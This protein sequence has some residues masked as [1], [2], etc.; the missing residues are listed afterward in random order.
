VQRPRRR[1]GDRRTHVERKRCAS[2]VSITTAYTVCGARVS[3]FECVPPGVAGGRPRSRVNGTGGLCLTAYRFRMAETGAT[4]L[5]QQQQQHRLYSN[6]FV[7][8][9]VRVRV[10]CVPEY[11]RDSPDKNLRPSL[12]AIKFLFIVIVGKRRCAIIA[13]TSPKSA[14]NN[15]CPSH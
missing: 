2:F 10:L 11:A 12:R 1:A 13:R 6:G 9:N 5:Q 3:S 4:R 8:M 15:S 7:H 14:I